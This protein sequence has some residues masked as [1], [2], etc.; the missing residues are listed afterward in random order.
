[1]TLQELRENIKRRNIL[2][3]KAETVLKKYNCHITEDRVFKGNSP[4][5]VCV[6]IY[7]PKTGAFTV[8]LHNNLTKS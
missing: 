3:R 1:M 4:D 2:R 5:S 6:G 8:D 7:N